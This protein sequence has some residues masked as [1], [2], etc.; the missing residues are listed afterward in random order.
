MAFDSQLDSDIP[1]ADAQMYVDFYTKEHGVDAGKA[2]VKMMAPG[3]KTSVW[4]QPVRECDKERFP[5]HWLNYLRKTQGEAA[6]II[7]T[8]LAAWN[9]DAPEDFTHGQ[10]TEMTALGFQSVE[11]IANASDNH[12]QRV[13]MGGPGLRLKA[14]QWLGSRNRSGASAELADTKAQLATLQTQMAELLAEKRGPGRP[15]KVT[16]DSNNDA[17]AGPAGN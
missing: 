7:G 1:N 10:V 17:G 13:G 12:L 11:H 8:P 14:Q 15:R 6:L 5:R 16:D 2:Y 9:A 3:D 4:D